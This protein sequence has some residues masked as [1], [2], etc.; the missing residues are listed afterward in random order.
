MV[1]CWGRELLRKGQN[2]ASV[3]FKDCILC[4]EACHR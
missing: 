4:Q 1:L 2:P 3:G